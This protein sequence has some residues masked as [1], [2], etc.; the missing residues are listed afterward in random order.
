MQ[1]KLQVNSYTLHLDIEYD[2]HCNG[3]IT[4]LP[5]GVEASFNHADCLLAL[6]E[7]MGGRRWWQVHHTQLE[8]QFAQNSP[9]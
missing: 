9:I 6:L 1:T 8:E 5:D 2:A 7:G 4:R 3:T